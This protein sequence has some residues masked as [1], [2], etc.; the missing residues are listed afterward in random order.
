MLGTV[1]T[2][3]DKRAERRVITCLFIDIVGSTALTMQAPP[4]RMKRTLDE[5][6]AELTGLIGREAGTV[7]KYVGDAIFAIFGAPTAHADDPLRALRAAEAC[8]AWAASHGR[9]IAIRVGIE[10]GDALVDLGATESDRQRMAVGSCVNIAARLQTHAEPGQ[11]LIGPNCHE[12]TAENADLEPTGPLELKGL[13]RVGAW[14]LLAV[15][16]TPS[17]MG[18]PLVGR[19]RELETLRTALERTRLGKSTFVVVSGPPGQGKTR[20]TAEFVA[21]LGPSC[22][23]LRARC[24]P[25]AETGAHTP[26]RQILASDLHE[27][28][29]NHIAARLSEL[30]T[31]LGARERIGTVLTHSAGLGGADVLP[32][33][34]IE[35]QDEIANGW[36][37]YLEALAGDGIVVMWVEDLHWAEPQLVRLLDRLTFASE[38]R[39]LLLGTARP[40]FTD[41][42][43][44]RP[45]PDRVLLELEQLDEVDA[46]ALARSAGA[47]DGDGIERAQGN[48]LFIVE[49]ARSRAVA[50]GDLPINLR[51]AIAA[52]LDELPPAER[53]LLQR[54]AVAGE[55]FRVRDAALLSDR[56]S[57]DVAGALARIAHAR[58]IDRVADGYRFHHPLI[59]EVAYDR[60]PVPERMRLHAR[61]A[62]EAV[63][64]EDAEALA[65]H[66]WEA[67]RP[68]DAEWV[69]EGEPDLPK[70]RREA[71]EAHLGAGQRHADRFAHERAVEVYTHA[72]A[73]TGDD[74]G[75]ATVERAMGVAFARNGQGDDAW[76]HRLLAIAAYRRAGVDAP[77]S[78]Y[79]ETGAIPVYNYAFSRTLPPDDV[80]LELLADGERIA[81]T[82]SDTPALTRLLVQQAW[83]VGATKKTDEALAIIES[84]SDPLHH[85]ESLFRLACFWVLRAEIADAE[86]TFERVDA[87]LGRGAKVD[88]M[89]QY[90]IYRTRSAYLAGELERAGTI[91]DQAITLSAGMGP[92]L[93]THARGTLA[94]VAA[95]RGD[96]ATVLDLAAEVEALVREN[97]STP[98]CV[99]GAIALSSGAI[100][101]ALA[102]GADRA[103]AFVEIVER[104]L[105][106]PGP[107]RANTL[108]APYV[109]L[110]RPG[111]EDMV[112]TLPAVVRPWHLQLV[113][114]IGQNFAIA[115]AMLERWDDLRADIVTLERAA[116]KGSR[117]AGAL[118]EAAT[119]E[120]ATA[121]GGPRPAHARLR[122]LGYVGLSEQ[123]SHRPSH[124]TNAT[125]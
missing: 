55:T 15:H 12:A 62:R 79:A 96:W 24:R 59:H 18:L 69:W 72:L 108:I 101:S 31:D 86:Q 29:P 71:Y 78:L 63:H 28:T 100:A 51:G 30:F 37:R 107:Q 40:E 81:R 27:V 46:R 56:E 84:A 16:E 68:P 6:F 70:M 43:A 92:H 21:A 112:P 33:N 2:G 52:R 14:R 119:E 115:H 124:S 65:H 53:E 121:T 44:L 23:V 73:F 120:L 57:A 54:S 45:G 35:R 91:A 17:A 64:P 99:V 4:E 39:L 122:D 114:P 3:L 7:E 60:L 88:E 32:T 36:R 49:L 106:K 109:M 105:V 104:M 97:P 95:A 85:V 94:T 77:A 8:A 19:Q 48:P 74:L 76:Q 66:W 103:R 34:P 83:Y 10:T 61:Y 22:R 98:W 87:L 26:L 5:A 125:A 123:L 93:K 111:A 90:F 47:T 117:L 75:V 41:S 20:L 9:Q 118:A 58:Y 13:G 110:E 80:V 89:E 1:V 116:A 67:L 42:A 113:D 102:G 11:I 82:S 50:A 25:G 38:T